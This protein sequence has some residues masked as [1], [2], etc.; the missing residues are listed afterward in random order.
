MGTRRLRRCGVSERT[1]KFYEHL[2]L[3]THFYAF[4]AGRLDEVQE[5]D[6]V[7]FMFFAFTSL[8]TLIFV[9]YQKNA[10]KDKIFNFWLSI[11]YMYIKSSQQP[12]HRGIN[13]IYIHSQD[14]YLSWLRQQIDFIGVCL[15]IDKRNWLKN[16]MR[17][18]FSKISLKFRT[19][20][21]LCR[22]GN[23]KKTKEEKIYVRFMFR[24]GKKGDESCWM[25]F[26]S[27]SF[28]LR[29][30]CFFR[31]ILCRQK[32]GYSLIYKQHLSYVELLMGWEIQRLKYQISLKLKLYR[33]YFFL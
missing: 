1:E 21:L 15:S 5:N 4:S 31:S 10:N 20:T 16:L 27:L 25:I 11:M 28:L 30:V 23:K 8:Y 7:W 18:S 22:K 24:K 6:E 12:C 19:F 26:F 14:S 33:F 32:H 29:Q 3:L 13:D 17:A 2:I 9:M